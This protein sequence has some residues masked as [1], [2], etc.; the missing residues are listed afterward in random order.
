MEPR[1]SLNIPE[2]RGSSL[3][4]YTETSPERATHITLPLVRRGSAALTEDSLASPSSGVIT[5]ESRSA[6]S[7]PNE[8]TAKQKFVRAASRIAGNRSRPTSSSGENRMSATFSRFGLRSE[9]QLAKPEQ[10]KDIAHS[11]VSLPPVITGD[12]PADQ[13]SLAINFED[14]A[15]HAPGSKRGVS[16]KNRGKSPAKENHEPHHKG[17]SHKELPD[18]QC[19]TQ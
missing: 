11:T 16:T 15:A 19:S 2:E 7:T 10:H 8:E 12:G 13:H 3:A 17:K 5:A 6:P 1:R 9:K 14:E 4:A 18:R